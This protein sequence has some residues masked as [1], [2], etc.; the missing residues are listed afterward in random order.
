M[1]PLEDC[2]VAL[3]PIEPVLPFKIGDSVRPLDPTQPVG[4]ALT[5]ADPT[6]GNPITVPNDPT[7][8]GWEYVW[9]CHLL[10][11]EENDMMRPV[12]LAFSPNQ[13]T[14]LTAASSP[15]PLR[16]TLNWTGNAPL[17]NPPTTNYLVQRATDAGFTLGLTEFTV[18]G[19]STWTYVDTAVVAGTTYFY[20]VRAENVS[21]Y[22]P[23][24]NVVN[25]RVQGAPPGPLAPINLRLVSRSTNFLAVAWNNAPNSGATSNVVQISTVGTT[26][27][28]TTKGTVNALSTS[29][30]ILGL[31]TKTN[32]WVRVLAT[33]ASGSTSS[34]VL[35]TSTL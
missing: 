16:V 9:H 23:W 4:A 13:P 10:G 5:V 30:T 18:P 34:N 2:I 7:N 27:P 1:N 8:F 32:Y 33:N 6:T 15:N 17:L 24:S 3:R 21:A 31:T 28:W 25:V 14:G 12:A 26:G 11:H 22:S 19:A 20:R 29:F 35:A